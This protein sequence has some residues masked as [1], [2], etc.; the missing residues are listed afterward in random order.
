[1]G[2]R[3]RLALTFLGLLL[4]FGINLAVYFV[5]D[6]RQTATVESL[7]RAISSQRILASVGENLRSI[8]RQI[9]LISQLEIKEITA[10]REEELAQFDLQ[11]VD[12]TKTIEAYLILSDRSYE[13]T[14]VLL[15][16]TFGK[17]SQSWKI[18]Y[19]NFGV[20][21]EKAMLELVTRSEPL[22]QQIMR[23]ILPQ[24]EREEMTRVKEAGGYFYSTPQW[25]DRITL[26]IFASSSI[27]A[28]AIAYV[29]ARHITR[30]L[31]TLKQGMIRIE[32]GDLD[33]QI[34]ITSR[35][36]FKTLA[37]TFNRM[38]QRLL[39]AHN[40]LSEVNKELEAFSYSVSHDLQTPLRNIDGFS[41]ALSV[42]H[43][44]RMDDEG[45]HYL[46]RINANIDEMSE[47]ID[48]LLNLSHLTRSTLHIDNVDL[49]ALAKTISE[50]IKKS[51]QDRK[52]DL[53][54]AE[55]IIARGDRS[56]LTIVL[57]NLL[58]NAFKYTAM[59]PEAK[60][61]FGMIKQDHKAIYF[62]RD[63][64]AGFDMKNAGQLFVPF[65]RMHPKDA[66]KGNGIGLATVRRIIQRHGGRVWAES[67]VEKGT[68]V[69][70]TLP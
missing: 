18:F 36:E 7:S 9:A 65:Q 30:H 54:I 21:H 59:H 11:L 60:I 44:D 49:S 50:D 8:Q 1:M 20:N 55:G 57:E 58:N 19:R 47:L 41:R 28:M 13:K 64:G 17:L 2:L 15:R 67:A 24:L 37:D 27:G 40:Q 29:L 35:D 31:D 45:K 68:T 62:V 66:F 53:F 6:Q 56:L 63:D 25:A 48:A 52:I 4:L 22:A 12:L 32:Q 26:L 14:P 23:D 38:A 5:S 39:S 51:Q 3:L 42:S 69:F 33:H 34:S 10:I 70:F 46:T 61:E 43:A 16:H